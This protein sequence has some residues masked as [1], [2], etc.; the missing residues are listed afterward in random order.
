[1]RYRSGLFIGSNPIEKESVFFDINLPLGQARDRL[2]HGRGYL[3]R[4]G[5]YR[6]VQV[7]TPGSPDDLAAWIDRLCAAW[8]SSALPTVQAVSPGADGHESESRR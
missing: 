1:L 3:V 4:Q 7:A 6:L 5:E 8:S 2:P